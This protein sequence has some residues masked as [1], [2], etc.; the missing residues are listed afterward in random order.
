MSLWWPLRNTSP[1]AG[2]EAIFIASRNMNSE[3]DKPAAAA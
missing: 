1:I 3:S 2:L